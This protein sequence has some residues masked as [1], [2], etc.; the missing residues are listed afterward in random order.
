M[1]D[2]Q[3]LPIAVLGSNQQGLAGVSVEDVT[4]LVPGSVAVHSVVEPVLNT[5]EPV[6]LEGTPASDSV[7]AFP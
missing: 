5:T 3:G 4:Q 6:P 1:L 2:K 7:T